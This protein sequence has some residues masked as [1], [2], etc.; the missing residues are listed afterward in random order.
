MRTL[1]QDVCYGRRMLARSPGFTAVVTVILAI[2]I[3]ATTAMLSIVDAVLLRPPPY[4]DPKS[5]VHLYRAKTGDDSDRGLASYPDF[6]EWRNQSTVFEHVAGY[7]TAGFLRAASE[8]RREKVLGLAVCQEYFSVLNVQPTLGR[9]FAP[10]EAQR[11]GEP[12]VLIGHHFWQNWFGGA[13]DVV[14]QPII[15]DEKVYTVVGVLPASRRYIDHDCHLWLPLIPL[16]SLWGQDEGDRDYTCISA[17]ARLKPA[18]TTAQARAEMDLIGRR[19]AK[20]YPVTNA[21]TTVS[22][23][24][25]ADE[26]RRIVGQDRRVF[27]IAQGIVTF[28]LLIACLHVASLLLIRSG[29]REKEIAIRATLGAR[30]L[31]L[32]RQLLTEGTLLALLGGMVGLLLAHWSLGLIAVLRSGPSSSYVAKQIQE[33]IPR[34][35]DFQID[36]RTLLY[37]LGVSLLTCSVFGILPAIW[38]SNV[39]L[40]RSLSTGRAPGQG[41]RFGRMRSVLVVVDVAIAFVLLI[42]AGLLVNSYARLNIGIG[43]DPGKVLSADLRPDESGPPYSHFEQRLALFERILER[44]RHM[45]GVQFATVA[46]QSPAWGGGSNQRFEIEGFSP[47]EFDPEDEERFPSI[48]W[49]QVSSD[50]FRVLQ[51][52]LLKGRHFTDR[53]RPGASA[54][55]IISKS[56]ARR[57]WPGQDPIGKHLTEAEARRGEGPP[58]RREYRVVGV[59]GDTRHFTDPKTGPPAPVIYASYSQTEWGG[60][61]SLMLRTKSDPR[62]LAKALRSEVL[63]V[64]GNMEIRWVSRLSDVIAEYISPQRFNM[65][66]LCACAGVALILAAVGV[67]GTTAYAVSRRTHEI[68]IRMAL[69]ARSTDVMG[70]VLQRGLKL[71]LIGLTIG[72]AGAL[73]ATRIIRSLLYDVSPT[74]PLTFGCV[75]LL[76]AGMALLACY[77]PARRAARIDPMEALRYE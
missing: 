76:L 62:G 65:L 60:Y 31:R 67:Y 74:D 73:G 75:S 25:V 2:G 17:I 58:V 39:N 6:V 44:V 7:T 43:Y 68:G 50:Y 41:K 13:S 32:I 30:R 70:A 10:E 9:L 45:P 57:F 54:V 1:W 48:R 34:F 47:S 64:E 40:N 72:L 77:L 14:D 11:G 19:S 23:V 18:M 15:L 16:M 35:L 22:V 69:G 53:D 3:G 37:T 27:F 38:G 5:L 12:V 49:R 28:V 20:A 29:A 46:D 61:M 33:L 42:G 4:D 56:M 52:P 66:C 36:A 71:T 63:A 55:A 59:V 24:P 8:A 51:I 21:G 26:H